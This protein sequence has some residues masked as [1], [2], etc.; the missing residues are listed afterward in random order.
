MTRAATA[1]P[2]APSEPDGQSLAIEAPDTVPIRRIAA[3]FEPYRWQVAGLLS[4][5]LVQGITGVASPFL[6]R[7]IVD[8][9]LPERS[10]VLVTWFAVG[11]VVASAAN[12]AL[13]VGTTWL[14]N[15]I[16]QRVMHD[17]RVAV[18]DH[19][20][21]MS[22]A[23]FTRTRASEL[24]SRIANDIGGVDNVITN[25][26]SSTIQN[27]F[28]ALA[29]AIAALVMDVRLAIVCLVVVPIF[30]MMSV[31]IGR[32]R[33]TIARGRQ[34]QVAAI[35]ALVEESLSVAGMLLTKSMGRQRQVSQRFATESLALSETEMRAAMSGKWLL[36]S[37]RASLTMVPA[38]VYWVAGMALAHGAPTISIGT[39]V[40]FASMLNRL[41]M[42]AS[43]LQGI[44]V[45]ASTSV[46]LFGRIFQVL[47]LEVDIAE[48]PNARDL[49]P[50]RGEIVIH[51]VSFRYRTDGPATLSDIALS[52]PAGKT[53]AL[54]GET[55]SGKT[56]LAYLIGRLYDVESGSIT[57]DG[58]DVRDVTQR[59]LSDAVGLVAQDTYLLHASVRANL[60]F[61]APDATE[62][63]LEQAARAARIHEL[64]DS[65]PEGYDTVVGA[66]GYRFSGGERQRIA[67]AR[68]LLRNPPILILDEAT[69]AL[70]NETERA[71]QAALDELS[72]GR[73]TIAIAHRLS[74][75][76]A[77][78]QI[79]VLEHGRIIELGTHE[80]LLERGG[81]YRALANDLVA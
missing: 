70:D 30:L 34:R 39:A 43:A 45:A 7:E 73:T 2:K 50:V 66:R 29:V 52:I 16:G 36:T 76:R 59:S 10:A 61:A 72:R 33:R 26:A 67:I 18:F 24:Q 28:A 20:Q 3:L 42:P 58:H 5:S 81:R 47:D 77:A 1:Q 4:V 12:A 53:T 9:A 13:G 41:V 49:G 75:V 69:S 74:T 71:V 65:L 17:L 78:E 27:V 80:Q 31:R 51:N 37:R 48:R 14:S 57:I 32:K 63:D 62:S 64:I 35:T 40:A 25:T 46:A 15:L 79:V 23:F 22:L 8:R 21:Q 56:T 60:M 44:G 6:L 19:L 55:G 38:I 68:M 11:M 54:V